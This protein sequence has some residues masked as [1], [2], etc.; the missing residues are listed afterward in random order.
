MGI[1]VLEW[2]K[3]TTLDRSSRC[4]PDVVW[5]LE[6][7]PWPFPANEFDEVHAYEILEHLGRQGDE[8]AF[9]SHFNE[10]HRILKPNGRLFATVPDLKSPWLWGDPG[11]RRA[12]SLESLTF[13][14]QDEYDKQPEYMSDYRNIYTGDFRIVMARTEADSFMFI[15]QARK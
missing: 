14:C 7:L 4:K 2:K 13:L 8:I 9:F 3:L 6:K 1:G 10:L 15:L 11:H 5:N 12:I